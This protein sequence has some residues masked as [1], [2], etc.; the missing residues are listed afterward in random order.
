MRPLFLA[1]MLAG[2]VTPATA[3]RTSDNAVT[4]AQ[5]AFGTSIGN[6]TIGLYTTSQVRGFSPIAAGNVRIDGL[7][8]DRQSTVSQRLVTGSAIRVGLSAQG[9]LFPA[10]TGIVDYR[11]RDVGEVPI[12]SILAGSYAYGA[13]VLEVDAQLPVSGTLGIAAGASYA[14]EEYYDGSDAHNIRIAL[15]PRWRPYGSMEITP[16]WSRSFSKDEQVAP[17]ILAAGSFVLPEAPRR[18]YFGQQWAAKDSVSENAGLIIKATPDEYWSVSAGIFRSLMLNEQNFAE[19]FMGT[20]SGGRTTERIIADPGQRY[21]STSGELRASR[22]FREATRIH[23]LYASL[24]VRE[25]HSSYGGAASPL[26]LGER[27]LGVAIPIARPAGFSFGGRTEDYVRQTTLGIAYEG[28]W[29]GV[30]EVTLGLQNTNYRKSVAIPGGPRMQTEDRLW[31]FNGAMAA[32]LTQGV[33]LYAGYTRGLEES[34]LAPNSAANRNET[35]PATRTVQWDAGLRWQIAPALKLVA[36]VFDVRKPYF[37]TD[38]ANVYTVLGDVKHRGF[39]LSLSGNLTDELS[40]VAGAVV[41][42]ARVGGIAADQGQVGRKALGQA[43]HILRANA[44]YRPSFLPGASFDI[45]ISHTGPRASSRD[46]VTEAAS[47]SLIDLGARYR[48]VLGE[49]PATIRVQIANVAD[50]FYWNIMGSSSY[51][52]TD[53]RRVSAFL[54]VDL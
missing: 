45:A 38:A 2:F 19:L 33:A 50:T 13:P 1:A 21:A 6:E 49:S 32:H 44:E 31:L 22:S 41:M 54:T 4:A 28:R 23:A 46:N 7:Y 12:V 8:I 11:L 36:G 9:Y 17:T 24:R 30:G 27:P 16:F 40:L 18:R 42:Q 20:T 37:S 47:Y 29:S 39:E 5:D 53:G 43:A 35:L 51:G 3:Q 10:P 15:I 52:L 25:V 14:H 34:G 26:D 48:F